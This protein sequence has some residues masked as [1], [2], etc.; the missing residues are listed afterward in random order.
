M[1]NH[2]LLCYKQAKK[3]KIFTNIYIN[4]DDNLFSEIAKRYKINFYK[5]RKKLGGSSVKSDEVV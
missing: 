4:S 3:S 5:R 2:Y 1:E